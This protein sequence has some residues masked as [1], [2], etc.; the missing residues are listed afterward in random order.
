MHTTYQ[1]YGTLNFCVPFNATESSIYLSN[2]TKKANELRTIDINL[3]DEVSISSKYVINVVD[4]KLCE[5]MQ[6][7][8]DLFGAKIVIFRHKMTIF[9]GSEIWN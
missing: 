2:N 8:T 1:H 4:K 3:C 9:V 6:N 5:H 7:D